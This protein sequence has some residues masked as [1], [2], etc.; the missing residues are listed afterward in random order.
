MRDT[1]RSSVG[2][3]SGRPDLAVLALVFVV[4]AFANAFAMVR[5]EA[6]VR[7]AALS[8]GAVLAAF[9][10]SRRG[11]RARLALALVPLGM[12][13]WS[14]HFLFHL[15]SGWASAGPALVHALRL[16]EPR[17]TG[18]GALV[19]GPTLLGLQL[20]LLDLGVLLTLY[21]AWRS[22]PRKLAF[23]PWAAVAAGLWLAGVWI[24]LQ[25]MPMRGMVH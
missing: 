12:A 23:V 24:C 25:P 17:W 19:S 8:A 18:Y 10:S 2:R 5:P 11:V 6:S 1:A 3:F 14:A 4:A 21:G 22:A 7:F 16:G 13:M 15:L 20:V 9:A